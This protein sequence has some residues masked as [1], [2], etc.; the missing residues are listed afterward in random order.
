MRKVML[1]ALVGLCVCVSAQAGVA[2]CPS[3][4]DPSQ[5][6]NGNSPFTTSAG[7]IG[8]I[9]SAHNIQLH[10]VFISGDGIAHCTYSSNHGLI[11]V[12]LRAQ[13]AKASPASQYSNSQSNDKHLLGS[14]HGT[15]C[16]SSDADSCQFNIQD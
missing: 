10:F 8:V 3:Q 15:N 2:H 1:A 13:Y 12:N 4:L 11:D 7:E 16:A 6:Q 14:W 5:L 9:Q